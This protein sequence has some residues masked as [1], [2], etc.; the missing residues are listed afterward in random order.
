MTGK[1]VLGVFL[2]L[3]GAQARAELVLLS[4]GQVLKVSAFQADGDSARLTLPNGGEMT[5]SM[6]RVDRVLDD[7]VEEPAPPA[8]EPPATAAL[9]F[10]VDYAA[11]QP[12]PE[13][14]Y[15]ALIYWAAKKHRLN[16][17]LVVEVARAESS[18]DARALSSKGACGLLQLMPAT[19]QRFGLK[20]S[21]LFDPKKNLEAGSRYLRWL[22]D[23][24]S[25][26]LRLALA[27]YN[28]GEH[29]V[30]R[31]KGVPPY[32]ETRTYLSRIYAS[33]GLPT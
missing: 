33:L 26:D 1:A 18:F 5:L 7:E 16:P 31:H 2:L 4:D 8:A 20:R 17:A 9:G 32:R 21:E 6:L 24:F 25:G 11:E 22:L 28:A 23:R 10:P 19:G 27:A 30:D 15:G 12:I 13:V 29:A 3:A 14:P